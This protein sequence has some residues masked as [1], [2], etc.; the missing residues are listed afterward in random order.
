MDSAVGFDI[1]VVNLD[2]VW[3]LQFWTF[4]RQWFRMEAFF[5]LA[6]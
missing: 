4:V 2:V 5:R 3:I 1:Q 6:R